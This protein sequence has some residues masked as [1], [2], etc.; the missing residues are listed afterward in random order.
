MVGQKGNKTAPG[1]SAPGHSKGRLGSR[2]PGQTLLFLSAT[3][4][5]TILTGKA[6]FKNIY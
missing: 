2:H 5:D 6:P 1:Q 4:A 3:T